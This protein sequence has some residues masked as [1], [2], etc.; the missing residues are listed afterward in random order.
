MKTADNEKEHAKMWFKE[1]NGI[2]DADRVAA[3]GRCALLGLWSETVSWFMR[4]NGSDYFSGF[5]AAGQK[6]G[7][8]YVDSFTC[9][10]S[11]AG[12]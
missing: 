11:R 6:V 10:D 2:G 7:G 8:I 1:L 4:H 3:M 9:C 12:R 5:A